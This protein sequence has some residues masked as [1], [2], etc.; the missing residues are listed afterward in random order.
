M[1]DRWA[2]RGRLDRDS[3]RVIVSQEDDIG[4]QVASSTGARKFPFFQNKR[5]EE[6][7]L[8]GYRRVRYELE[9]PRI[10]FHNVRQNEEA[11]SWVS[12][13]T[14]RGENIFLIVGYLFFADADATM[15]AQEVEASIQAMSLSYGNQRITN[16]KE[17]SKKTPG[18]RI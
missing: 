8:A 12:S 3:A 10:V 1:V 6:S 17:L 5:H 9:N 11:L 16:E 2:H 15:N 18:D 4:L 7:R 13:F 14:N